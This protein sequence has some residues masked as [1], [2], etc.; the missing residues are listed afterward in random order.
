VVAQRPGVE[1]DGDGSVVA[2]PVGPEAR[3]GGGAGEIFSQ[4]A[5]LAAV[6]GVEEGHE[7]PGALDA[8]FVEIVRGE[9]GHGWVAGKTSLRVRPGDWQ[10][11]PVWL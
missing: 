4:D 3:E 5:G 7:V 8:E 6:D 9:I 2:R 11:R 10:E 1:V